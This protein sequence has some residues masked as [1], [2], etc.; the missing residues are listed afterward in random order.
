MY[1]QLCM[2]S[3]LCAVMYVQLC[4]YSYVCAVMYVQLCMYSYV[5]TVLYAEDIKKLKIKIL[6]KEMCISLVHIVQLYYNVRW[7][8]RKT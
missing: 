8:K 7:K 1:V 4:M 6:I 3:Y 2:C 5:C